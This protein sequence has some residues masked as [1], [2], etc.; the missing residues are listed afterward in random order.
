MLEYL[1][2]S[3]HSCENPGI[4]SREATDRH[5][6]LIPRR[7]SPGTKDWDPSIGTL[8]IWVCRSDH[9]QLLQVI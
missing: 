6:A 1:R 7:H 5:S 2:L 8:D 9:L 4:I 3:P